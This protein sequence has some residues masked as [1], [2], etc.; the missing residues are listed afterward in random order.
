[1]TLGLGRRCFALNR[2]AWRPDGAQISTN[3]AAH[4]ARSVRRELCK[5]FPFAQD[6]ALPDACKAQR[7]LFFST[8]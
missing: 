3:R 4:M 8:D 1:M 6:V 7:I 2:A 5:R